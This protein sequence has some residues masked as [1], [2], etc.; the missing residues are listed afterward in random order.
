MQNG[1]TS[2]NKAKLKHVLI[3]SSLA[4]NTQ[5]LVFAAREED[6]VI[7]KS[8]LL[9][10]GL[11]ITGKPSSAIKKS[12]YYKLIQVWCFLLCLVIYAS[13]VIYF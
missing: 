5:R 8:G 1:A 13:R 3:R 2:V 9:P 12:L 11:P 7:Y 10:S 6:V 4:A